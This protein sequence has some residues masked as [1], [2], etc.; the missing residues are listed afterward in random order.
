MS[1][2]FKYYHGT[3]TIFLDSIRER[4]LGAVN[5]N[6]DLN[7]LKVLIYLKDKCEK[8]LIGCNDYEKIRATT[9]AMAK[10]TYLPIVD[11][12]GEVQIMNYQHDGIYV[13]MSR[14]RSATY[15]ATNKYG[16]EILARCIELFKQLIKVNID[17]VIPDEINQFNF[18]QYIDVDAKPIIIEVKNVSDKDLLLENGGS[19]VEQLEFIRN[20]LPT[21]REQ[22]KFVFLQACNFRILRPISPENLVFY[23][24]DFDGYPGTEQFEIILGKI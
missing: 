1:I 18:T 4:G 17:V 6:I 13:S 16:S 8:Y 14:L 7:N 19:A 5:P 9:I 21:M 20:K 10:Q 15:V 2:D 24:L 11:S 3:S 12:K 23:E 22:F